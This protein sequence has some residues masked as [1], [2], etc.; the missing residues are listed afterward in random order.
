MFRRIKTAVLELVTYHPTF[1]GLC[2]GLMVGGV[3]LIILDIVLI[4]L[5]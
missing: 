2:I 1:A 4:A 3:A 5:A